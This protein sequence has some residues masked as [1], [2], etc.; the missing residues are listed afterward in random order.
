MPES[1]LTRPTRERLGGLCGRTCVA[2]YE[3]CER[4]DPL[5]YGRRTTLAR[6]AQLRKDDAYVYHN[7][8]LGRQLGAQIP[9]RPQP[10][11]AVL[12]SSRLT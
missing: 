7:Y 8:L 6:A 9:P 3:P 1:W 5:F 11:A 12:T 10:I 2:Q 4:A